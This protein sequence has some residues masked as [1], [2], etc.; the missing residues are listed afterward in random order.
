MAD[1]FMTI[2]GS[3]NG[4]I[5]IIKR[6]NYRLNLSKSDTGLMCVTRLRGAAN[7]MTIPFLFRSS[8]V[9]VSNAMLLLFQ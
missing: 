1:T 7:I 2:E 6:S 4:V 3:F 5:H 9:N 8:G